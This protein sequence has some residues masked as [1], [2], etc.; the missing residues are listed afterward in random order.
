[1][2]QE[3]PVQV[4]VA[5]TRSIAVPAA[6]DEGGAAEDFAASLMDKWGVGDGACNDGVLLLLSLQPRQV[7]FLCHLVMLACWCP[8]ACCSWHS[9]SVLAPPE[10]S[11]SWRMCCCRWP[12]MQAGEPSARCLRAG[13]SRSFRAC[14]PCCGRRSMGMPWR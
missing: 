5:A 3:A 6:A 7:P 14:G 1:M 8:P 12:S 2:C 9:R 11:V 13:S 4:A 10:N